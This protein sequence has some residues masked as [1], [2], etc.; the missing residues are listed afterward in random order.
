MYLLEQSSPVMEIGLDDLRGTLMGF[1]DVTMPG[2]QQNVWE[3]ELC[4][5]C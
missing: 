5:E 4:A 1:E 3:E 2:L